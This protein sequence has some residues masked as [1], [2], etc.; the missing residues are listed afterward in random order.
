M[1]ESSS[2]PEQPTDYSKIR[3]AGRALF[4]FFKHRSISDE[5]AAATPRG[6]LDDVLAELESVPPPIIG[7]PPVG[8]PGAAGPEWATDSAVAPQE[9]SVP[10][11]IEPPIRDIDRK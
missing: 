1:F 2:Y 5:Q 10:L 8:H 7:R 11:V 3:R 4:N 9:T 6:L